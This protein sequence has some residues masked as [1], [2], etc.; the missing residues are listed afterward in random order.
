MRVRC[1]VGLT[2]A[3]T[4]AMS[5]SVDAAAASA[6]DE[7]RGT[8]EG[9]RKPEMEV[10]IASRSARARTWLLPAAPCRRD[11]AALLMDGLLRMESMAP[12]T[13]NTTSDCSLTDA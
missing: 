7:R 12:T 5:F 8:R 13:P 4:L 1:N 9:S 6:C 2:C 11:P 3:G 10:T